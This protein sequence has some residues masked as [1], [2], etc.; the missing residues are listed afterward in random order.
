MLVL[1]PDSDTGLL[2]TPTSSV[3]LSASPT[4]RHRAASGGTLSRPLGSALESSCRSVRGPRWQY[5]C[6]RKAGGGWRFH[7]AAPTK[8]NHSLDRLAR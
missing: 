8:S 1:C 5:G 4:A 3:C 7:N 6:T 2:P